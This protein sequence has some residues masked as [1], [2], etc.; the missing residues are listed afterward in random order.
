MNKFELD[1]TMECFGFKRS[2][3]YE[4][5]GCNYYHTDQYFTIVKGK[6]PYELAQLISKKYDNAIYKIRVN[7]NH[8]SEV[9]RGDVYEYHIDTIEGL[10]A[11]IL[12]TQDYYSKIQE[13]SKKMDGILNLASSKILRGVNPDI[14]IYDWMLE[15][16]NRKDYFRPLLSINPSFDKIRKKIKIFDNIINP[17]AITKLDLNNPGFIVRGDG[18][19]GNNWFSLVDKESKIEMTTIRKENGFVTK[20]HLP[21]DLPYG[22][23][24]YHSFDINGERI[25]FETDDQTMLRRK[26]Y[27]LTTSFRAHYGIKHD[28]IKQ[29]QNFLLLQALIEYNLTNPFGKDY[30]IK[31]AITE[32][33]KKFILETLDEYIA[34]AN[35][36]VTKNLGIDLTSKKLLR[37]K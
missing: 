22:T 11:F 35:N 32:K 2:D 24:V 31:H 4:M 3:H 15:Q 23:N 6:T 13:C 7:G 29:D 5:Y 1:K 12:E 28:I 21:S 30:G 19:Q 27:N 20:L 16:E 8:E 37:K 34:L 26:E 14:S 10:V 17:F 9:P 25:V 18:Y 33:D 36:V